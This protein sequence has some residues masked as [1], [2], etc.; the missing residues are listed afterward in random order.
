MDGVIIKKI[1]STWFIT[2]LK[3][4][5]R[6][7]SMVLL[8][9]SFG[10]HLFHVECV[11]N[12]NGYMIHQSMPN[13]LFILNLAFPILLQNQVVNTFELCI[14]LCLEGDK[15]I[16]SLPCTHCFRMTC[17]PYLSKHLDQPLIMQMKS[18]TSLLLCF[19]DECFMG[20]HPCFQRHP[21]PCRSLFYSWYALHYI[22]HSFR[23]AKLHCFL[24]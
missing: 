16:Y 3:L 6:S 2:F 24:K 22:L 13:K 9:H 18:I 20:F 4:W 19:S 21:I 5:C 17:E 1:P 7:T 15:F 14:L 10:L 12:L 11:L 8:H 23:Y